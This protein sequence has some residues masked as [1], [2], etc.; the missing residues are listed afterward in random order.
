MSKKQTEIC[1]A[2]MAAINEQDALL[3]RDLMQEA[4]E[5]AFRATRLRA[6]AWS[7]YREVTGI[8]KR[9]KPKPKWLRELDKRVAEAK[10]ETQQ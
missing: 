8:P 2:R 9:P 10:K 6:E 1:T 3:F 7:I 5:M 4:D